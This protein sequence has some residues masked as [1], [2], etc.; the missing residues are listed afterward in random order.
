MK[1]REFMKYASVGVAALWAGYPGCAL[2]SRRLAGLEALTDFQLTITEAMV[3][4]VDA[5]PVYHW[6]FESPGVGPRFPGPVLNM[7]AG[8]P[9][10]V[11]VTNVL[12][13]EHAFAVPGVAD[14][15]PILPGETKLVSF[16]APEAG[17]YLYFDPLNA[18]VNRVL[19]LHG[20]M[21]VLPRFAANNPYTSPA[22]AVQALFDDLGHSAHFP[23]E[24]WTAE[25]TRIWLF[26]SID[27]RFNDMAMGGTVIDPPSMANE[28]LPRYFTING[29]SG[30]YASHNPDTVPTG[31][32]GQ[33][34]LIRMLNAGIDV[35]SPHIHGNHVY[36]TAINGRAM[37]SGASIGAGNAVVEATA[38]A[39]VPMVDTFSVFPL[40]RVDWLLPF[41]RPP[42]IPGDP[43]VPLRDL[44]RNEL[45]M[46][47]EGAA[48]SPLAYPMHGHDELSQTAAGGNY[49]QG[50][51]THWEITGDLDGVDFPVPQ[52]H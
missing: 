41:M 29:E 45:A 20:A 48:Q 5:R 51:V 46:T 22:P 6:V 44:L 21:V 23:G 26:F 8:A 27:P 37:S 4:M 28:F 2:K 36:V 43:R 35:H 12:G 19:G 7:T 39:L 33:P 11:S 16:T 50:L 30:A 49:P 14:S 31:R 52:P 1:R 32:I 40:E 24:P 13:E 10:T 38:D 17:T 47:L 15:G 42:D 18:P 34:C 3:E 25:R 9:I